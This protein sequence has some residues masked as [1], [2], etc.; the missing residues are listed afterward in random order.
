MVVSIIRHVSHQRSHVKIHG[1][2]PSRWMNGGL[3]RL[4]GDACGADHRADQP[5]EGRPWRPVQPGRQGVPVRVLRR[6]R[7]RDLALLLPAGEAMQGETRHNHL[8]PTLRQG[9]CGHTGGGVVPSGRAGK[10]GNQGRGWGA[11]AI[12]EAR[13][14]LTRSPGV[15]ATPRARRG[16]GRQPCAWCR[17]RSHPPASRARGR[18]ACSRATAHNA[19]RKGR[20]AWHTDRERVHES[21]HSHIASNPGRDPYRMLT[22]RAIRTR[23]CGKPVCRPR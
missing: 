9:R 21:D 10:D 22:W 12:T 5:G 6:S 15:A 19:G 3:R 8:T 17:A 16:P 11:G 14:W 1:E 7:G 2:A 23:W 4:Q 13:R 20:G 18:G